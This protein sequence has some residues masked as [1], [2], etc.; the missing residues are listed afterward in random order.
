[1]TTIGTATR[2]DQG[3]V[4]V[5]GRAGRLLFA[6]LLS[7][8]V[9]GIE[10][11]YLMANVPR[12]LLPACIAELSNAVSLIALEVV[13]QSPDPENTVGT[14]SRSIESTEVSDHLAVVASLKSIA[15]QGNKNSGPNYLA[16]EP[17]DAVEAACKAADQTGDIKAQAF[18]VIDAWEL[19]FP[20]VNKVQELQ[21][22]KAKEWVK[23]TGSAATV[24]GWLGGVDEARI[25]AMDFPLAWV[26]KMIVNKA[27]ETIKPTQEE[28]AGDGGVP[29]EWRK[30]T[31]QMM[32]QGDHLN[33][34]EKFESNFSRFSRAVQGGTS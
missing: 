15:H 28:V 7:P 10:T 34:S 25:L 14:N 1:M 12:K 24:Y 16:T 23:A 30:Y 4:T 5:S 31:K 13:M 22:R 20:Q 26:N 19:F 2:E 21:P 9:T 8:D 33:V 18:A 6:L 29:D 32:E 11:L 3:A 17:E 27:A